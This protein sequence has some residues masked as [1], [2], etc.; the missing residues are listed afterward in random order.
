MN[1][2]KKE[3]MRVLCIFSLDDCSTSDATAVQEIKPLQP[4]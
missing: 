3:T 2:T 1:E 4:E